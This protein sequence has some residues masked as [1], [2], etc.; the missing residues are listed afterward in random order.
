MAVL[1][2]ECRACGAPVPEP[3]SAEAHEWEMLLVVATA[4][5]DPEAVQ[6]L[7]PRGEGLVVTLVCPQCAANEERLR[8][9]AEHE[10]HRERQ[11]R[12]MGNTENLDEAIVF[13]G[14]EARVRGALSQ[15]ELGQWAEENRADILQ[16]STDLV[17]G[18]ARM[19]WF[20]DR[21]DD[22]VMRELFAPA[23]AEATC[24]EME[25]CE[26]HSQPIRVSAGEHHDFRVSI[27]DARVTFQ[28]RG[29]G[30]ET[31][32]RLHADEARELAGANGR[33]PGWRP[34][35]WRARHTSIASRPARLRPPP[36]S[37]PPR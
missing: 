11:R 6:K 2:A 14:G 15:E 4:D 25:L 24:L 9:L 16:L 26:L 19:V 33:G 5:D 29:N 20:A 27:A 3:R 10:R 18:L 1:Q 28:D 32:A 30:E 13:V 22:E 37:P 35:S 36:A 34:W 12:M 31:A 17:Q 7:D 23:L 21:C 8:T